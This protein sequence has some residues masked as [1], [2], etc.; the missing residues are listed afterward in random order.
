MCLITENGTYLMMYNIQ[1]LYTYMY[2]IQTY[3][4]AY[5]AHI[6]F[7]GEGWGN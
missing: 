5:D 2:Y 6:D 7:S 3:S 4:N 1:S